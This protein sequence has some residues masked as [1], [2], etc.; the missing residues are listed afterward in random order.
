MDVYYDWKIPPLNLLPPIASFPPAPLQHPR[1]TDRQTT[2]ATNKTPKPPHPQRCGGRSSE[3]EQM[4]RAEQQQH[5]Q[6]Q[7]SPGCSQL[8]N[9][10]EPLDFI[11][12]L[13][14]DAD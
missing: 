3:Q 11:T 7:L 8:K 9:G 4:G 1:S 12:P 14:D 10:P 2:T 6:P 13:L 5:R